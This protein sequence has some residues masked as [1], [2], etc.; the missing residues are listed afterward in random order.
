MT[1]AFVFEG[2]TADA[3]ETTFSVDEPTADRKASLQD[4]TGTIALLSGF[5]MDGTDLNFQRIVLEDDTRLL[6]EGSGLQRIA[7]EDDNRLLLQGDDGGLLLNE[8]SETG[9]TGTLLNEDSETSVGNEGDFIVLDT[10][11][12]ENDRLLFEDGTTDPLAVLAS[13]GISLVGQ[14]WNAFRFDNT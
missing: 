6:L 5:G 14:G 12:D 7:L 3:F 2:A 11:D 8:N 9:A 4:K 1:E 10:S 13:H